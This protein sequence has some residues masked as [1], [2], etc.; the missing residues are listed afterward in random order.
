MPFQVEGYLYCLPL[1]FF[2]NEA[3]GL[4]ALLPP[5]QADA[6]MKNSAEE[7]CVI[8]QVLK[9]EM[10][11]WLYHRIRMGDIYEYVTLSWVYD[12]CSY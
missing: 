8:L 4:E 10:D 3:E 2:V 11:S 1:K 5:L 12:T 9:D 6:T 7:P